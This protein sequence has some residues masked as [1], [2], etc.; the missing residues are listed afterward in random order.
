MDNRD[1]L[2]KGKNASRVL[3]DP[4]VQDALNYLEDMYTTDWK[5]S[6]V[7]DVVK[8]ERAFASISVLQDFKAALRSYVDSGKIAGRQLERDSKM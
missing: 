1:K 4:V 5:T 6:T 2:N 8:R 7:D 3:D